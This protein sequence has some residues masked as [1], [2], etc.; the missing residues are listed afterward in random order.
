MKTL[1]LLGSPRVKG[2]TDLLIEKV[3]QGLLE[4]NCAVEIVRLND[5]SI[6]PCQGCGGCDKTGSCVIL[7]DMQDLYLKIDASDAVIIGSP[8]YFYSVTAQTKI[9]IDRT[10]AMWCRKY[11]VKNYL[12]DS[13]NR[14]GYFVCVSATK[15]EKI[16][17]GACLTVKYAFDAM[18]IKYCDELLVKG[19]DSKGSILQKKT[20]LTRAYNFG[21]Q[22]S[23]NYFDKE[24]QKP[25]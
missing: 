4:S 1:I 7:D 23:A 21:K 13:T 9:A 15:G 22:I 24:D 18:D 17:Q 6:R 25:A 3:R 16:F 5:H 10:Q 8:I 12:P 2:N 14:C 11:K 20:E 19:V